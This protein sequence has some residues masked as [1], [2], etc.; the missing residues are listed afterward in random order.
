MEVY[1]CL[2]LS[3]T[4]VFLWYCMRLQLFMAVIFSVIISGGVVPEGWTIIL[5]NESENRLVLYNA[6]NHQV[7]LQRPTLETGSPNLNRHT[8]R[9]PLCNSQ[10]CVLK[11]T[12]SFFWYTA[13]HYFI[14]RAVVYKSD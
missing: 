2:A 8:S 3:I 1:A 13:M 7:I 10:V 9:C 4:H 14:Y 11:Y 5:S 12:E 6:E